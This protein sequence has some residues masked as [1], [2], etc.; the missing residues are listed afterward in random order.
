MNQT[1]ARAHIGHPV[2]NQNDQV[3]GTAE[4]WLIDAKTCTVEGFLFGKT[5]DHRQ[6][7]VPL[8]CIDELGHGLIR[9]IAHTPP[10]PKNTQRIFGLQAWTTSPKFLA[11]FVYDCLFDPKTGKIETFV[12]HQLIRTWQVPATAITQITPKALLIDTDT[13]VKLKLTPFPM[14]S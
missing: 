6:A 3:I 10:H 4:T 7:F 8:L 12:V 5:T 13:T 11:G 14:S 1:S 9:V 2:I